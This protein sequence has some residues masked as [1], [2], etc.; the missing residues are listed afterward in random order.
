MII[1]E[2]AYQYRIYPNQKQIIQIAKTFGCVRFVYNHY[3]ALNIELYKQ[4]Q[5]TMSFFDLCDTLKCLKTKYEW[6]NEVDPFA[7]QYALKHLS[8]NVQK[9]LRMQNDFPKFKSKKT[10]QFSYTTK[11]INH[12]INYCTNYINMPTLG[13]LKTRNKQF[14]QGRILSATLS[15]NASGKYYVSLN[16]TNVITQKLPITNKQIGID[17][18]LKDYATTSNHEKYHNPKH[19][20]HSLKKL[21]KLQKELSRK[22]KD[23]SNWN[24]TRIKVARLQEHFANQRKDYLHKLSIHII[25][26]NDIICVENLMVKNMMKNHKLARSIGD[27]SWYEFVRQLEY[28]AKWYGRTLIKVNTWY[29]SSQICSHCHQKFPYTKDLSIRT[30]TCPN[31]HIQ[32]DRDINAALNILHEGMKQISSN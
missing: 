25:R 24:K 7:L 10:H 26:N 27:A 5:A 2:K 6:L 13:K 14:P 8:F 4:R 15:Q 22:T 21:A 12:N 17:L 16:C 18:G 29:A 28:K 31:C 19:L 9:T 30:W 23:S 1:M 20:E 11:C 32:L 3:L